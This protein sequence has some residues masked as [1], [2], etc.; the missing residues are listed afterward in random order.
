MQSSISRQ[1][2]P[3]PPYLHVPGNFSWINVQ[4]RISYKETMAWKDLNTCEKIGHSVTNSIVF[5]FVHSCVNIPVENVGLFIKPRSLIANWKINHLLELIPPPA[6]PCWLSCILDGT[7][8]GSLLTA[9]HLSAEWW[10][11]FTT[12]VFLNCD[13][14]FWGWSFNLAWWKH[15]CSISAVPL[16]RRMFFF[17]P[18]GKWGSSCNRFR[19]NRW[20]ESVGRGDCGSL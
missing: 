8:V 2:S 14:Y 17:V 18:P 11:M 12:Q 13:H 19:L 10:Y 1:I 5:W 20:A 6:H 3:V 9:G 16:N 7:H 15:R 4:A